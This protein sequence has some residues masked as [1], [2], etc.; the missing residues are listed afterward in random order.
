MNQHLN[1]CFP[2]IGQSV[3]LG[4]IK[5]S[6]HVPVGTGEGA[7]AYE[8][9]HI[10]LAK[11]GDIVILRKNKVPWDYIE[12][13]ENLIQGKIS[14]VEVAENPDDKTKSL[15]E[16]VLESRETLDR[17]KSLFSENPVLRIYNSTPVEQNVADALGIPLWS[18]PQINIKYGHKSG[19]RELA[20][21]CGIDT[22][23]GKSVKS[24]E[25]AMEAISTLSDQGLTS[26]VVKYDE[27]YGGMGHFVIKDT[28]DYS[29]NE[30]RAFM[31]QSHQNLGGNFVVEAWIDAYKNI[32]GHIEIDLTGQITLSYVWEKEVCDY[33]SYA[34]ARPLD[35]ND[36]A[37]AKLMEYMEKAA[38]FLKG[39]HAV[40]SYGPDFILGKD[41]HLYFNELN[42]RIPATAFALQISQFIKGTIPKG[43]ACTSLPVKE[44][45][46]FSQV[47]EIFEENRILCAKKG[48]NGVVPFHIGLL[49]YGKLNIA[50]VA[51]TDVQSRDYLLKAKE[52]TKILL[53][54]RRCSSL[55]K[56]QCQGLS[57]GK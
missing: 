50:I 5:K 47:K 14:I 29:K 12:Y 41:G 15:P 19:G 42:A 51:D 49:P 56:T 10:S 55:I 23:P 43:F 32:G 4:S 54:D 57:P 11:P 30:L 40:G 52:L 27:S 13:H 1:F 48:E 20:R 21:M 46:T 44:H 33:V 24:S 6:I 3:H 18:S 16:L 35:L 37:Y 39:N 8:L 9:R 38:Q 28:K 17:I 31:I 22:P 45:T 36:S 26:V 2:V 53:P 7:F 34:G 25:E